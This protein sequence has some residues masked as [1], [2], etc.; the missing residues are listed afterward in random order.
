MVDV[1]S[2]LI[3]ALVVSVHITT[4]RILARLRIQ[5]LQSR[6]RTRIINVEWVNGARKARITAIALMTWTLQ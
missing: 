6:K 2:I 1:I 3:A 4:V 5:F